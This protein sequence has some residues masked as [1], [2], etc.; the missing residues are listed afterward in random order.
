[1][2]RTLVKFRHCGH[3]IYCFSDHV[4]ACYE[5]V[6]LCSHAF[7]VECV[8]TKSRLLYCPVC[9]ERLKFNILDAPV[10]IPCPFTNGHK[11]PCAFCIGSM[12]GPLHF[13]DLDDSELHVGITNSEGVVYNYTL[14]GIRRD[15]SGWEQCISVPL[16]QPDSD[17]LKKQWDGE[18]EQFS[19]L[20]LWGP[21]R[22]YEEREFGSSCYA[23][24]LT[25]INHMQDKEGKS[26]LTRDEFTGRYVLPRMKIVSK[27]IKVYQEISKHSFYVVDKSRD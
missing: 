18:L 9:F 25:F 1:M 17:S 5:P 24:V 2:D 11:V 15:E 10:S 20:A 16:V 6:A 13:S 22:F 12:H 23:F 19:C 4:N 26:C 21:E 14:T 7:P 27:Y 8:V 3:D